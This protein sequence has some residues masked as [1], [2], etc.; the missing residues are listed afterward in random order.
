MREPERDRDAVAGDASEAGC[1]VPKQRMQAVLDAGQLRDRL[2][3]GEPVRTFAH[4]V[5]QHR[6]NLRPARQLLGG[7][8]VEHRCEN[9]RERLP[10]DV[11]LEQ[12]G[13][14]LAARA[15]EIAGSE[16]L[17]GGDALAADDRARDH[18]ADDQQ[19]GAGRVGVLDPAAV[20][21]DDADDER[22]LRPRVALG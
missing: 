17:D 1:E 10:A 7:R 15:Q 19:P 16:Q 4:A 13:L 5:Q 21:L 18:A 3:H 20:E 8:A 12:V 2:R 9:G 14:V 22:G 11:E 6:A